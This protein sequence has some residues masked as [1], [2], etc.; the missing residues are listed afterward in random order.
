MTG[1]S[2]KFGSDRVR[3]NVFDD[4]WLRFVLYKLVSGCSESKRLL[5]NKVAFVTFNYDLSVE[6]RL[7]DGLTNTR[8]FE[9]PDVAEFFRQQRFL[10]IHGSIHEQIAG[11]TPR[12]MDCFKCSE[13][14]R[15][16][17]ISR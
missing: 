16:W 1:C 13:T 14:T 15:C 7:F 8:F 17:P 9:P 10:H 6:R 2:R 4:D 5:D 11:S 3:R 12:S